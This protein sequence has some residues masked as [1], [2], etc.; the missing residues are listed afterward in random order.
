[1]GSTRYNAL[2]TVTRTE[3][4]KDLLRTLITAIV[5]TGAAGYLAAPVAQ[6]ANERSYNRFC[7][8]ETDT[9]CTV[10]VT[11][12]GSPVS[13][14]SLQDGTAGFRTDGV[15]YDS[16]IVGNSLGI[17]IWP[18]FTGSDQTSALEGKVV[19]VRFR[20]PSF[21]PV[22][23]VLRGARPGA[24]STPNRSWRV[25]GNLVTVEF[26][27]TRLARAADGTCTIFPVVNDCGGETSVAVSNKVEPSVVLTSFETGPFVATRELI[28]GMTLS[29]N[30]YS[31]GPPGLSISQRKVW[32]QTGG[33][34]FIDPPTVQPQRLNL[35]Y[36]SLFLPTVLLKGTFGVPPTEQAL[37]LIEA[38]KTELG[39]QAD[40]QAIG[41][42]PVLDE[43]GSDLGGVWVDF[44]EFQFSS[45][46]FTVRIGSPASPAPASP[47]APATPP[48]PAVSRPG[49][50]QAKW[51]ASKKKRTVTAIVKLATGSTLTHAISAK[52]LRAKKSKPGKCV[53]DK[54]KTNAT[55]TVKLSKGRWT[56]SITP[57]Q[58]T[59]AGTAT[60]KTFNF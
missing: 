29:L 15:R 17:G 22:Y 4:G 23:A 41:L 39:G 10:D 28:R 19:R 36:M 24:L 7:T 5:V 45:P 20:A 25:D 14:S 12:D 6:A 53:V 46:L 56:V 8:S 47:A 58:G 3:R 26:K 2:L 35:G 9:E 60:S 27:A 38:S 21:D 31:N 13:P 40:P 32:V 16:P 42:R 57:S 49:K 43:S 52:K 50:P 55:C 1:M 51:K 11:V 59:L 33:P 34:H 54:K 48:L 18:P 44:P 37:K 30:A